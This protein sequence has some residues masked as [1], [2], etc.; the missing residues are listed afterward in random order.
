MGRLGSLLGSGTL[1]LASGQILTF[2]LAYAFSVKDTS[3]RPID[4]RAFKRWFLVVNLYM[5]F[6]SVTRVRHAQTSQDVFVPVRVLGH[7]LCYPPVPL[8]GVVIHDVVKGV[9]R[10]TRGINDFSGVFESDHEQL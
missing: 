8:I 5:S 2:D 6:P 9:R 3:I 4:V 10:R 7:P 1:P